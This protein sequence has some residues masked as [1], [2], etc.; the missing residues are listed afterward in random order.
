MW[1]ESAVWESSA[2]VRFLA[3]TWS[4]FFNLQDRLRGTC[5]ASN[6]NIN[7]KSLD[8]DANVLVLVCLGW[9][10]KIS[11]YAS[12]VKNL[13]QCFPH[14]DPSLSNS[15]CQNFIQKLWKYLCKHCQKHNGPKGW[16]HITSS[17]ILIKFHLQNLDQASTSKSQ[18]NISLST[19]LDQT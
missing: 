11:L 15:S 12:K 5:L 18:S 8:G 9:S 4:I 10:Q 2:Q 6:N 1:T 13:R 7:I 3:S 16:V 19:K 14:V 17:Q